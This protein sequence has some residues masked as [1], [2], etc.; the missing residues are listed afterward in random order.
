[1][2]KFGSQKIVRVMF[3]DRWP[4]INI[5]YSLLTDALNLHGAFFFPFAFDNGRFAGKG[6]NTIYKMLILVV[7]VYR[8]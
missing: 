2:K 3:L 7:S 8:H 4:S 5:Q 6:S 1:M